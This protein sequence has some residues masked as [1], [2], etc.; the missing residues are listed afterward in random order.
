[1]VRGIQAELANVSYTEFRLLAFPGLQEST[2]HFLAIPFFCLF[3]MI[4]TANSILIYIVKSEKSLHSPMYML[5]ALL[6]AV[7]TAGAINIL[8]RMVLSFILGATFISLTSCL[9]QMFFIYAILIFDCN[10]LLMMALDRYLA[11]CYPLRYADLMTNKLLALLVLVSMLRS[12]FVVTPVVI[13]ASRVSFCRS[14]II[15]HFACEHMALMRLSCGDISRN[16][17]VGM[18]LRSLTIIFDVSFLL[19]SYSQII[20][21]ALKI[22]SGTI[23]HKAFHTCGTH[24][25]VII[26]AYSTTLSSSIVFRVAKAASEDVHNLLSV[27][28]LLFP[29]A[30]NP[31][32]YGMRTKEIRSS[33][34]KLFWRKCVGLASTNKKR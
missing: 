22:T 10:V 17:I 15:G 16:K 2:R 26:I 13:L 31:F 33:L 32:I 29:W 12:V 14:N 6:F 24:L 25:I 5:I 8:P 21:T 28:Y 18:L 30:I 3:V 9:I 20:H 27:I 1:M 34:L 7:N 11:I 4:V 23:K 19:A